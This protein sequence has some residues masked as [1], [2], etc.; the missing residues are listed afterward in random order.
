[1][2]Y[3]TI[4][5]DFDWFFADS[6]NILYLIDGQYGKLGPYTKAAAIYKCPSDKS[7]AEIGGVRYPRVRSYSLNDYL[8]DPANLAS[9]SGGSYF[10]VPEIM[11]PARIFAFVDEHEDSIDDGRLTVRLGINSTNY[12]ND[13]PA[14]L[15][16][17]ACSLSFVDG[18]GE[19]KKWLDPRTTPAPKRIK[20]GYFYCPNDPDNLWLQERA[21]HRVPQVP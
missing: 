20:F 2:T 13:V 1:M 17:R 14:S 5:P 7:W 3:E 16:N 8:G 10:R 12:W 18:H 15:H 6:T 21:T 19:I 4:H 11:E 9:D